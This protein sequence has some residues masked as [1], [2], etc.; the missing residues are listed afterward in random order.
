MGIPQP[1]AGVIV[2]EM[3]NDTITASAGITVTE[4]YNIN[5]G[6]SDAFIL[7]HAKIP[8]SKGLFN[9]KITNKNGMILYQSSSKGIGKAQALNLFLQLTSDPTQVIKVGG[10]DVLFLNP[11]EFDSLAKGAITIQGVGSFDLAEVK[12]SNPN[13]LLYHQVMT[14]SG[15]GE[16]SIPIFID[17]N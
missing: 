15:K 7:L 3:E 1:A 9:F 6:V 4:V 10:F 11:N 14:G 8:D 13:I 16:F 17:V 12:I 2:P 5:A